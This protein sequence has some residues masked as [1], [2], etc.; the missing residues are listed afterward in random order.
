MSSR[1]Q[2]AEAYVKALR[3][4]EPSASQLASNYLADDVVLATAQGEV[5]GRDE[6][7]KRITGQWPLTPVFQ[8]AGFGAPEE[9]S[10][11]VKLDAELPPPD[12]QDVA[13]WMRERT[14]AFPAE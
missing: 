6:V 13:D 7:V 14:P 5:S 1:T 11:S 3:T 8:H 12:D 9:T 2:A 10:D 4:G